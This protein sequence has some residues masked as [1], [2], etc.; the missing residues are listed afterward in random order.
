MDRQI[1]I[2]RPASSSA[3][4]DEVQKLQPRMRQIAEYVYLNGSATVAEV[5]S[6]IDNPPSIYAVRT[7]LIRLSRKGILEARKSGR[8]MSMLYYP[9]IRSQAV[10]ELAIRGFLARNFDG[11][12]PAALEVLL[13]MAPLKIGHGPLPDPIR[14]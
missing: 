1:D 9:A 8:H 7:M 10:K 11:S 2:R 12:A 14:R 13:Q 3:L 6:S 4:P 5:Q